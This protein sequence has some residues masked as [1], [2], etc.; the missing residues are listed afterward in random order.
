[1]FTT[2][3]FNYFILLKIKAVVGAVASVHARSIG[4]IY[5]DRR[6]FVFDS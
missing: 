4:I 3:F 5:Y 6:F 2:F 1:M